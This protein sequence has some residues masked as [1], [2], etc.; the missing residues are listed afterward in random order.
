MAPSAGEYAIS[1]YSSTGT[2]EHLEA[3]MDGAG[4]SAGALGADA[5]GGTVTLEETL[6]GEVARLGGIARSGPR[7]AGRLAKR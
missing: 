3:L 1:R 7:G 2:R 5:A 4:N 6:E